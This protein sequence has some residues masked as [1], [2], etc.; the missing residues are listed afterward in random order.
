MK[1]I[2]TAFLLQLSSACFLWASVPEGSRS[3]G[4]AHASVSLTDV[5]AAHNNPAGLAFL[6]VAVAAVDYENRFLL[7][8]LSRQAGVFALPFKKGT[9]GISFSNFGY[10]LFT[11]SRY[12]LC[13]GMK[14]GEKFSAGVQM[15]YIYTKIPEYGSKA[16]FAAAAG[17]LAK[18]L[19]NFTIGANV[20]NLSGVRIAAYNEERLPVIMRLGMDYQFSEK[21]FIAMEIEKDIE[22]K[23][24]VKAGI[25]YAPVKKFYLRAGL[26]NNPSFSSFGLGVKLKNFQLDLSST[27]HSVLG[28]SPQIGLSYTIEK[29]RSSTETFK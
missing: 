10:S 12:G 23:S 22:A 26:A 20:Y 8:A 14:L 25:E 28:I 29:I 18:P 11:Q 9:F 2:F 24:I 3:A 13:Y 15:N 21:V 5:W 6:N 17:M 1:K 19:K 4:L 16:V 27:F 7:N